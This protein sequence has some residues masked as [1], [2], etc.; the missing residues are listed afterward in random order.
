MSSYLSSFDVISFSSKSTCSLVVFHG[1]SSHVKT[2][3]LSSIFLHLPFNLFPK[4]NNKTPQQLFPCRRHKKF[5][6]GVSAVSDPCCLHWDTHS[7]PSHREAPTQKGFYTQKPLHR[8]AFTHS[9]LLHRI[10]EAFIHRKLFHRA[11]FYTEKHLHREALTHSKLFHTSFTHS[12]LLHREAFTQRSPFTE[13]HLHR[14]AFAQRRFYTKLLNRENPLTN[15]YCSLDAAT[16]ICPAAKD[17]SI[18][19]TA[20]APNNL[21]AVSTMRSAKAELQ[22]TKKTMRNGIRICSSKTE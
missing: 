18:M 22:N 16:P 21:D 8:E 17:D 9:K 15:P 2:S 10:R 19:H 13:K 5:R 4:P 11:S 14:E 7:K 6:V 1:C 3:D 12:Q 20:A